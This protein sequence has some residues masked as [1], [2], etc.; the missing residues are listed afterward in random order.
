M[1][2]NL[3]SNDSIVRQHTAIEARAVDSVIR[4]LAE[5]LSVLLDLLGG[6]RTRGLGAVLKTDG[7]R[8][9]VVESLGLDDLSVGRPAQRPELTVDE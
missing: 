9:D 5:E 4:R 7:G 3:F 8:G 6:E 1:F 2:V